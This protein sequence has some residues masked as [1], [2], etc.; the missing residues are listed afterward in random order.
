MKNGAMV[1][2]L[3]AFCSTTTWGGERFLRLGTNFWTSG[4]PTRPKN[5]A[6]CKEKKGLGY[7]DVV[8]GS[9]GGLVIWALLGMRALLGYLGA[10]YTKETA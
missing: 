2:V 3:D 10:V 7:W 9:S 8:L 6:F 1:M 5:I 4:G